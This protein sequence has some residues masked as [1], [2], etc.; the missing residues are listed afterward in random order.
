[1]IKRKIIQKRVI[2]LILAVVLLAAIPLMTTASAMGGEKGAPR[3]YRCQS[4]SLTILYKETIGLRCLYL[5]VRCNDCGHSMAFY[6]HEGNN[7]NGY[8]STC[9]HIW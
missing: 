7:N 2:A 9:G 6:S 3:C 5:E 8:C 4:T 1:M